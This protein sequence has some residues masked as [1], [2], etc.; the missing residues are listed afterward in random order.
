MEE[1]HDAV[2]AGARAGKTLK[3]MQAD[4]RLDAYKDWHN[5]EAHLPMNIEGMYNQIELHRRGN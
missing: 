4:I 3:Q 5:Y 2:L 1:L